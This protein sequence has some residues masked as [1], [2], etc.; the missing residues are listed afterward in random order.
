[1]N[2]LIAI[3]FLS[4]FSFAAAAQSYTVSRYPVYENSPEY[5][6][7]CRDV[8]VEQ[9]YN[10]TG[11]IVGA[12]IGYA[13]GRESG[14]G[15]YSRGY[16]IPAPHRGYVPGRGGYYRDGYYVG[17]SRYMRHNHGPAGAVV[18]GVIG[19]QMGRGYNVTRVCEQS[20]YTRNVLVG[21]RVVE[22]HSNG[23]TVEYFEP[24]H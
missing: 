16:V 4:L 11:A 13:I 21:H 17:G 1:M 12:A 24:I 18:G 3:V 9:R 7:S 20:R 5:T 10:P 15:H 14:H 19:S 22:R 2:K 6:E 23:R 8:V